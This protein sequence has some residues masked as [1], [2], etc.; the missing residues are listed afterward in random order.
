VTLWGRQSELRVARYSGAY[1]LLS[2]DY[3]PIPHSDGSLGRACRERRAVRGVEGMTGR[4]DG[5]RADV[6]PFPT[7]LFDGDGRLTGAVNMV[8]DI[9]E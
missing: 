6:L 8:V 5:T 1:R 3:T 4:P 7:P 2:P 9:T